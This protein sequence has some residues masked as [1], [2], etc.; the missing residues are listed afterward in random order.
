M[1]GHY[2]KMGLFDFLVRKRKAPVRRH[3]TVPT[4]TTQIDEIMRTNRTNLRHFRKDLAEMKI[5]LDRHNGELAEHKHLIDDH[6]TKLASLEQRLTVPTVAPQRELPP[7]N[8]PIPPTNLFTPTNP[9]MY[10]VPQRHNIESFSPQEKRILSLFFENPGMALSYIDIAKVLNKSA[11]T[12][13]NQMHQLGM[14]A[15]LF[16][17]TIDN[18]SRNRFKLKDGLKVDRFLNVN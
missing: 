10:P 3:K 7:I 17:R 13:K 18:A 6:T 12:V 16:E 2:F 11:N 4:R 9:P 14:K 5:T 1:A 8:R 15:D